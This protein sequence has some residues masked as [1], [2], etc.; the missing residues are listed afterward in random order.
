M[1]GSGSAV[2]L[3]QEE[4]V[5]ETPLD[6]SSSQSQILHRRRRSS[7]I[8]RR[9][10][11]L[12]R[13]RSS[14]SSSSCNPLSSPL[15]GLDLMASPAPIL[16]SVRVL[17]LSHLA[18]LERRLTTSDLAVSSPTSPSFPE[19]DSDDQDLARSESP[20]SQ[21]SEE[22]GMLPMD[23]ALLSWAHDTLDMLQRIRSDVALHLP[24]LPF[25]AQVLEE[26]LHTHLHDLSYQS[27]LD[28]L[29]AHLPDLPRPHMP[30]FTLSDV[31][32][33]FQDVRTQIRE[34]SSSLDLSRP[35]DYLPIL[36][37]HLNSLHAR[38]S[39]A[40]TSSGS[41]YALPSLPTTSTL[42]ELLD[43]VLSSDLV[44]S[45]LHRVDG[46]DSPFEKAAKEMSET[47]KKSLDGAKLVS[48]VDLP[49][50]WRSN[51][52][53]YSG[54]RFIPLHRW[55]VILL[56][57]FALHNETVN[58]YTHMIPLVHNAIRFFPSL[59]YASVPADRPEQIYT[60]FAM[61]C[62]FG[63]VVWHTMSGCAH[64]VGM[65]LCARVDYVGIGWLISASVGT[66]V[67]YGFSCHSQA[68]LVYLSLCVITGIAGSIFPFMR[69]F[70]DPK[71]R[72]YRITFFLGMAFTALAPLIHLAHLFSVSDTLSFI[73]PISSSLLSYVIG[74]VFYATHIPERFVA[75]YNE[76]MARWTDWIG[77]GSHAIWHAFIVLAIYQ[78]KWGMREMKL[79]VDGE[80]CL[81]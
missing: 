5:S 57:L 78:H 9:Q 18:E 34:M 77:G 65:E 50:E 76:R 80:G 13:P 79:G 26:L 22:E 11:A 52:W 64:Q 10:S 15:G 47:L 33:R 45:V 2:C 35:L 24:D 8:K 21:A 27:L 36:S 74:L 28:E 51:P 58:I 42:S 32:N 44:P 71:F 30:E 16:A 53:V 72:I 54:Y 67:Y 29:R 63:S 61:L 3:L 60:A 68:A 17:V 37:A 12:Q 25:D 39:S 62:L 20:N 1:S 7:P 31:Q 4:A 70:N 49:M 6:S 43:R 69:W 56:S 81:I 48:Y 75:L 46:N 73:S 14:S 38:L 19:S 41:P 55:P 59:N 66:V 23:E 40:S